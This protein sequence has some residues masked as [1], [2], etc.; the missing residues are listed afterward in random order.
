M[1][2]IEATVHSINTVYAQLIMEIGPANAVAM[3]SKMGVASPLQPYP[4]AVLGTNDVTP[5]DMAAAYATFAN[6]GLAVPPTLVTRVLDDK[7]SVLYEQTHQQKRVMKQE[8]ADAV[9]SV[10]EQVVNR[11]T[12]VGARI[13]RPVAGKTGTGE[14]W[15]DAWFVGYTPDLVTSVWV[16]F[17]GGQISMV[18]PRTRIRVLGGTW[19]AQAWQLYMS[20]ALANTPIT[21]FPPPPPLVFGTNAPPVPVTNVIGMP[22]AQAEAALAQDG[23][24]A[25]R[26]L[27]PSDQ[28][29]PGYVAAES[30]PPGADAPGG[31]AVTLTVSNGRA[32]ATVPDVLD[33]T[34]ADAVSALTDSGFKAKVVHQTEPKSPGAGSRKGRVW[35]QSPLGQSSAEAGSTVTIY[36]NPG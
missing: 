6:R 25:V 35:K 14:E 31:S 34:E 21:D 36:V 5:L 4:S 30:P 10:L 33:R 7:G 15:R 29:P 2:L 16:G 19:P 1:N 11:G 27:A 26:V 18:P 17:P 3:A 28:Y 12:G 23:F 22:V 20:T 32:T 8:T 24:R 9:T 13:G